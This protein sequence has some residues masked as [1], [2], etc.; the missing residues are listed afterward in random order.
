M[1]GAAVVDRRDSFFDAKRG[2]FGSASL[3]WG[4]RA[5]GSD[6]DYLRTLLRGYCYQPVGRVVLAGN[7]QWAVSCHLA[8]CRR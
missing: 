5:L 8:A 3:Q 7:L 1:N 4:E 6:L 2:W